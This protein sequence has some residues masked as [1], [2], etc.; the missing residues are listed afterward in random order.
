MF[1]ADVPADIKSAGKIIQCNRTDAGHEDTFEHSFKF[2]E[3]LAIEPAGMCESM[4]NVITLLI[5]YYIGEVI[6]F[7]DN[8]IEMRP[9]FG[10]MKI[11]IVQFADKIGQCFHFI[12]KPRIIIRLVR[13]AEHIHHHTAIPV[14]VL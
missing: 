3:N 8:K 11:Q 4:V 9:G 12:G 1:G 14:K 2:L 6:I 10:C 7:V 13:H 5:E